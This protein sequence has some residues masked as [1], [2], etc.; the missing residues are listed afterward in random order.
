MLTVEDVKAIRQEAMD[1]AKSA[2]LQHLDTVGENMYCGFAWVNIYGVKGN[3]KLGK[4]LK[5]AGIEQSYDKSYQIWN[6]SGVGTQCMLTKEV[7][8]QA[9]ADVFVKYGFRSYMG[10]RAD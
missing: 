3:T 2:A 1:A 9:A 8:A 6:P 7:G 10:S 5:A 4:T